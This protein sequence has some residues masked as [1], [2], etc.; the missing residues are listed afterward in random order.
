MVANLS[1]LLGLTYAIVLRC[2]LQALKH[3]PADGRMCP[4]NA[5]GQC[6]VG[7]SAVKHKGNDLVAGDKRCILPAAHRQKWRNGS[8]H[9]GG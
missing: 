8:V 5:A 2:M 1:A 3:L 7:S 9:R 4:V 6:A